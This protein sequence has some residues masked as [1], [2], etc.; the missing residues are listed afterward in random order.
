MKVILHR[1]P[2]EGFLKEA[3]YGLVRTG[4][5]YLDESGELLQ[6][7]NNL[8]S[9]RI[10]LTPIKKIEVNGW[11]FSKGA[12]DTIPQHHLATLVDDYFDLIYEAQQNVRKD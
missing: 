4:D 2:P 12:A 10:I 3:T 6:A 9:P 7:V 11:K 5:Y 8:L 1:R